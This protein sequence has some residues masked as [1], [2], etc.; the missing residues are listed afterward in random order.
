DALEALAGA[1]QQR[2]AVHR[3]R[4]ALGGARARIAFHRPRLIAEHAA[5]LV[6]TA[7]LAAAARGQRVAPVRAS[8]ER[9]AIGGARRARLLRAS[10][11]DRGDALIAQEVAAGLAATAGA[12]AADARQASVEA[13]ERL[14]SAVAG[15]HRGAAAGRALEQVAADREE[16]QGEDC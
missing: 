7:V 9:R 14:V 13:E 2:V 5:A 6:A 10:I 3:A 16:R 12:A 8:E 15:A 1:S 11:A 4:D